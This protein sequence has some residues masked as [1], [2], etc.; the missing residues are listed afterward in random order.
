M[1]RGR[2]RAHRPSLFPINVWPPLVDALVLVLAVFVLLMM[3]AFVAQRALIGRLRDRDQDVTRLRDEK[4]RIER[5]L[6]A[7]APRASIAIEEGKVILQGE[8]LFDSGSDALKP[9]G[10]RL[11]TEMGHNL[12]S[13]LASEPDQMVLIGGHTDD[14]PIRER[15]ASNWE[16]SAAR[17]LAVSRVLIHAGVPEARV[18]PSGFGEHHPRAPNVDDHA[19]A[20]NRRIEVLLVPIHAVSSR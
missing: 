7:L 14:R 9:A 6:R 11:M 4:A 18:V 19:R 10:E 12:A 3:V 17:A 13:L 20:Q 5:R 15:F 8:V 16:L 1:S 2:G